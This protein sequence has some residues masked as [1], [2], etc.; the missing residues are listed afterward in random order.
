MKG[1]FNSAQFNRT[2]FNKPYLFYATK[3]ENIIRGAN[4][5]ASLSAARQILLNKIENIIKGAS[6]DTTM[7]IL[8]T[9]FFNKTLNII[10]GAGRVV[11]LVVVKKLFIN[12]TESILRGAGRQAYYNIRKRI[13]RLKAIIYEPVVKFRV[14]RGL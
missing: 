1:Q 14:K 10:Q 11:N 9:A 6:R 2:I 8:L 5:I 12:K 4:R 7:G 3:A 13:S